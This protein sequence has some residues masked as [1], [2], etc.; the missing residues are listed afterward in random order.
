LLLT[1]NVSVL[2]ILSK[3]KKS[4]FSNSHWTDIPPDRIWQRSCVQT[5]GIYHSNMGTNP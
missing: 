1:W 3:K 2:V 4:I 5:R